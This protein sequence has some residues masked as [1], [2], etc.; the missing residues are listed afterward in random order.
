MF[1]GP[2]SAS[3]IRVTQES[4]L[5]ITAVYAAVT[6]IA[7]TA[8]SLPL[9][10]WS[11]RP[12]GKKV[13]LRTP[14]NQVLWGRPNPSM[15][16]QVFWETVF[17][18]LSLWGNAY[19]WKI[20]E[21]SGAVAQLWPIRPRTITITHVDKMT[22]EKTFE[23][24]GEPRSYSQSD[25]MHIPAFSLDGIYGLSP[26][27]LARQAIGLTAAAEEFGARFFGQGSQLSGV[28]SVQGTLTE[29]QSKRLAVQ[30]DRQHAGM[31][32]SHRPAILD[33]GATW[34]NI[35]IPPEDAQF[36]QTRQFQVAE[37][38]RLFRVPPHL[39][40]DVSGSTSW[41]TG[42]AEQNAGFHRY[43]LIPLLARAEQAI[44]DDP[45][46]LATNQTASFD[47]SGLLRADL[48]TRYKA[49]LLARNGGW[50]SPNDIR[51]FEGEDRIEGLDDY[52]PPAKI[53]A[54]E[55]VADV[56]LDG[57]GGNGGSA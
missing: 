46:L 2:P 20:K 36:L 28:L 18:C 57:D 4:A 32:N 44:S 12:D 45:D 6:L 41:G 56:G 29:P 39:I 5:G 17:G 19:F 54:K 11:N 55:D 23:V 14:G 34:Q 24:Q 21:G 22:G 1:N 10:V 35:G 38:A 43:T 40:G 7:G 51:A 3:G 37:I 52:S 13:A 49:Y 31:Q 33:N 15:T 25:I 27:G 53:T 16:R 26:I 47:P 9:Q 8:A 30:W 48:L 42:I 50:E